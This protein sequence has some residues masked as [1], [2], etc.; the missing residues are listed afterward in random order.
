MTTLLSLSV[1]WMV[2]TQMS[3]VGLCM[4]GGLAYQEVVVV[5]HS[6]HHL[7]PFL[8]LFFLQLSTSSHPPPHP[9]KRCKSIDW[10]WAF[11]PVVSHRF[12]QLVM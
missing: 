9:R 1:A 8:V 2:L 6:P 5:T 11:M 10:Q 4:R 3:C 12:W 7:P